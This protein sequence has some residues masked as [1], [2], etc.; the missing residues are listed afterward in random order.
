MRSML[1]L[2][3]LL[4]TACGGDPIERAYDHCV[5]RLEVQ[6]AEAEKLL[7]EYEFLAG[8]DS[9]AEQQAARM[10][11]QVEK[12]SARM[13]SGQSTDPKTERAALDMRWWS[14]GPI[15]LEDRER[16]AAR[17]Q[18]ALEALGG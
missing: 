1:W 18:R 7:L 16:L 6:L 15:S 9:P 3:A 14:T 10:N 8:V 4:L 17:R 2:G 13:S 5:D 11:L 12:L